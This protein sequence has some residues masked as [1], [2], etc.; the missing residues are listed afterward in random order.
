MS[1]HHFVKE[2]QE[3]ALVI[4][5]ANSLE[6]VEP[7]L[8]WAPLV[9]VSEQVL[10]EVLRWGIKV[11]VVAAMTE[12][13]AHLDQ[14]LSDHGP[15]KFLEYSDDLASALFEFL[16]SNKQQAVTLVSNSF[17]EMMDASRSFGK[18]LNISILTSSVR[19]SYIAG[20][21]FKKWVPKG[22]TIFVEA[23]NPVQIQLAGTE[24]SL[25]GDR[26]VTSADGI[27][28]LKCPEGFWVGEVVQ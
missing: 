1:S 16:V 20:G 24:K 9:I 23:G 3:P 11:D 15:V 19:W 18:S 26:I 2:G 28:S 21:H 17:R 25:T 7:L 6:A 5:E 13:I 12:N 27:V 10:D 4:L 8:E 14:R 22:S